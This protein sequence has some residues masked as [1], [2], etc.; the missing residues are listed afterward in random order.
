MK[1]EEGTTYKLFAGKQ[2]V[3]HELAGTHG[4][5]LV[6]HD[7]GWRWWRW[8]RRLCNARSEKREKR[9]PPPSFTV[10]LTLTLNG[11][12]AGWLAGGA[13]FDSS[14]ECLSRS[15]SFFFLFSHLFS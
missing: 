6:G 5:R 9:N 15:S 4:A 3:G 1:C 12:L 10:T 7:D 14:L 2:T 13:S 11:R 8:Q